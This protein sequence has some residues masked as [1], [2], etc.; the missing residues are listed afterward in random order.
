MTRA[1]QASQGEAKNAIWRQ[2]KYTTR[3]FFEILLH[4]MDRMD[5]DTLLGLLIP[6]EVQFQFCSRVIVWIVDEAPIY[7]LL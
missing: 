3:A 1:V 5:D 7:C 6:P 4:E 2:Q